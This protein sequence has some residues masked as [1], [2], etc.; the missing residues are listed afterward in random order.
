ML[1]VS[2]LVGMSP[3][4]V[5][6][7]TPK[8]SAAYTY[9][10][11][12]MVEQAQFHQ[13]SSP[14]SQKRY[15]FTYD[16]DGRDQ[17]STATYQYWT[18]SAWAGNGAYSLATGYTDD[19]ALTALTR[20]NATDNAD[21]EYSYTAGTHRLNEVIDWYNQ[22]IYEFTY[23]GNGNVNRLSSVIGSSD[24]QI[25]STSYDWR[26]LPLSMVVSGAGTHTYCKLT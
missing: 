14:H 7:S 15:R 6:S 12:G 11:N 10:A 8:F 26:N 24:Y 17:L 25:T 1:I 23:D 21:L 3:D 19:G 5:A 18:G 22:E 9:F 13:P 20:Y 2:I 4:V 16:Y